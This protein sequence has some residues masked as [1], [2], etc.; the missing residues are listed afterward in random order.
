MGLYLRAEFWLAST[1]VGMCGGSE[2]ACGGI[3]ISRGRGEV[4]AV[5]NGAKLT[6]VRGSGVMVTVGLEVRMGAI[7]GYGRSSKPCDV[8][9]RRMFFWYSRGRR[10]CQVFFWSP[11]TES[12]QIV[13][14]SRAVAVIRG[15]TS[16][17]CRRAPRLAD[18]KISSLASTVEAEK[19]SA[20][21][22]SLGKSV[23]VEGRSTTDWI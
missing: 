18:D 20:M 6:R 10:G 3:L 5:P 15:G 1:G 17:P 7:V 23:H 9:P 19:K 16:R 14:S 4:M 8:S 22:V 11:E 13:E 12:L 21:T 2:D